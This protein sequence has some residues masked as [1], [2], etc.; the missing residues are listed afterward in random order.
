M[1]AGRATRA[2]APK[3][4]R[5]GRARAPRHRRGAPTPARGTVTRR[6]RRRTCAR[7]AHR[8]RRAPHPEAPT[9]CARDGHPRPRRRTCARDAHRAPHHRRE[10]PTP[11]ARDGHPRPPRRTCARDAAPERSPPPHRRE[12]P[13]PCAPDGHPRPRRRTCAR[14]ARRAR[15][16]PP[17]GAHSL[18]AG[19]PPAAPV[20]KDL[21]ADAHRARPEG[22]VGA[23]ALLTAARRPRFARTA[24]RRAR[25]EGLAHR[26][27]TALATLLATEAP[28][29]RA[30]ERCSGSPPPRPRRA[31]TSHGARHGHPPRYGTPAG[32]HPRHAGRTSCARDRPAAARAGRSAFTPLG[33]GRSVRAAPRGAGFAAARFRAGAGGASSPKS[34]SSMSA[35]SNPGA[36]RPWRRGGSLSS[37]SGGV[38]FPS[39]TSCSMRTWFSDSGFS[40]PGRR[41]STVMPA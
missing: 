27:S 28:A 32:S 7:D 1:R 5:S 37:R 38:A 30:P 2:P 24:T 18:R 29:P 20:P 13:T 39:A 9:P 31:S 21:R 35:A 41:P 11:C 8:A 15:S 34:S 3:D 4:L 14:D 16:P 25:A 6:P 12:A 17:R 23:T 33:A 36:E 40:S 10:V 22:R 26:T 19:R